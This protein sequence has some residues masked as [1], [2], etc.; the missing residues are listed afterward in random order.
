MER[1]FVIFI[2][3]TIFYGCANIS[4]IPARPYIDIEPSEVIGPEEENI[5][6]FGQELIR[7]IILVLILFLMKP[8]N[9]KKVS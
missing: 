8:L 2:S 3:I 4:I 7:K 9:I 5:A 1:L 6:I